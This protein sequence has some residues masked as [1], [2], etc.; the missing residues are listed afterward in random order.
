MPAVYNGLK[1]MHP[2]ARGGSKMQLALLGKCV[3]GLAAHS[4]VH[5]P[6]ASQSGALS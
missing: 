6:H 5:Q 1:I 3:W 2:S 4:F